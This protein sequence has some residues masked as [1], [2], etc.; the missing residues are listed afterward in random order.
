M[1]AFLTLLGVI[2]LVWVVFT[3]GAMRFM[4]I[5][6]C[7]EYPELPADIADPASPGPLDC[8]DCGEVCSR[9]RHQGG[10]WARTYVCGKCG[11]IGP[12]PE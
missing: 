5:V 12:K 1:C 2:V 4:A 6:G 3:W 7:S 10:G 9:C 11:W 8:P